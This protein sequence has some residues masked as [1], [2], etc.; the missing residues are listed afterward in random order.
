MSN[1]DE[2]V[3]EYI[4]ILCC[5]CSLTLC[6]LTLISLLWHFFMD[7]KCGI[8]LMHAQVAFNLALLMVAIILK[9]AKFLHDQVCLK[10]LWLLCFII[11]FIN[12]SWMMAFPYAYITS[13]HQVCGVRS[14]FLLHCYPRSRGLI[15]CIANSNPFYSSCPSPFLPCTRESSL[16]FN[17]LCQHRHPLAFRIKSDQS[18]RI[19]WYTCKATNS[20][21]FYP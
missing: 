15:A 6:L 13:S 18:T 1:A 12:F 21:L 20:K 5:G 9:I 19:G 3:N 14:I 7:K 8:T 16:T 11:S 17:N 10:H 2:N 4:V